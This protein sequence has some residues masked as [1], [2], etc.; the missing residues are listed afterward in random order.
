MDFVRVRHPETGQETRVAAYQYERHLATRGFTLVEETAGRVDES[1]A[2]VLDDLT[3]I[4]GI[5]DAIAAALAQLGIT[6]RASLGAFPDDDLDAIPGV[7]PATITRIRA[8]L[9][10]EPNE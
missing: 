7:G 2:S 8:A 4:D 6:D 3:D 10:Q 1:T 9:E 5:D